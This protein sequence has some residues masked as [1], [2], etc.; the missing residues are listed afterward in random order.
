W[1]GVR[2]P[3]GG[4]GALALG[5]G[6]GVGERPGPVALPAYCCYDLATAVDAAGVSFVLYDVEPSTLGPDE[7]SL[8][9]ALSAGAGT[10]VVAHLYGVP[11]DMNAVHALAGEY[12]A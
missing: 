9:A 11:V 4:R 1:S 2:L 8:R 6:L 3:E 5:F 10:V 12:G 7:R